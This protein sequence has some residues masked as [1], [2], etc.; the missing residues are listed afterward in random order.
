MY[1]ELE[2]EFV[3][4]IADT[5]GG[6]L[7]SL[8]D[9][10][11]IEYLWSGD[12]KYW[13]GRSPHLFPV[14]GT[15]KNDETRI[16]GKIY[17]MEK[18]G[19]ARKVEY[20]VAENTKDSVT[21]L[22]KDNES[23]RKR[24][25]FKFSFFVTHTL[26]EKGFVTSYRIVNEDEVV[27]PFCVG[28]HVG[29]R[30]PIVKQESFEDYEV[31]FDK[32][33]NINAYFQP[34]DDPMTVELLKPLLEEDNKFSLNYTLFEEGAAIIDKI[35]SS[36]LKLKSKKSGKGVIFDYEGFPVLALWTVGKKQA[37]YIC[38]EPWHGLPAMEEDGVEFNKKPYVISLDPKDEKTMSYKLQII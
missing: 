37:P 22:L 4:A 29:V 9:K 19:I 3:H 33:M 17:A 21:F 36:S 5:F 18:H 24:F 32:K 15:L 16:N 25:P 12:E 23:T 31:V 27:M 2:N 30:C 34:N 11:G 13:T 10:Q 14:I 38:L 35:E 20:E 26:K 1:I 8:V 28:G 7:I 6:E